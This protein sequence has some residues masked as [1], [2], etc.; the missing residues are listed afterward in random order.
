MADITRPAVLIVRDGWGRNPN[1]EHDAFN[2]VHLARTPACDRLLASYPWTLIQT[3][4]PAVGLPEGTMGNSEVGHQ[5]LGAGRVVD[6]DSV[7][8]SKAIEDG[9]FFEN[10]V[11]VRAI[12]ETKASGTAV[13]LMGIASDAGVHGRLDHL[14]A[15]LELCRRRGQ[16]NVYVHLFTDGRDTGPFTGIDYVQEV[17]AKID[18]IGVGQIASVVGRYYAMDRDNRWQRT[19]MAYRLLT[20]GNYAPEVG[21]YQTAAEA[22]QDYYDN[23]SGDSQTGDEFV[24]PRT[25]AP[26]GDPSPSRLSD[27]DG[28]IF[29]N[30]RGDRPR[31]IIRSLILPDE[32]WQQVPPSPDTGEPGFDRGNRPD[33]KVATMTRYEEGL[34]VDVAFP[35]PP[36]MKS[37]SG[38]TLA[39]LGLTQFRC[40]ETEKFA[41]VTFFFNDYREEPFEGEDREMAQS[42]SVATYD[43]APEMSAGEVAELVLGR[44]DAQTPPAFVLV[45]F[46]NGD[47]VGHTGDLEAATAA[48]ETVDEAVGRIIERV[49]ELGGTAVVTADHGNAEQMYDPETDAPHTSHT[50]YDVELIVVDDR[51]ADRAS[52]DGR[53]ASPGLRSGGC[54][55][56]VMPTV[57]DLMGLDRPAPM[58]GRSLLEGGSE[59]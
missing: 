24:L 37:I 58:T 51:Y 57:L 56:D 50:L 33:V 45:N 5:N 26:D 29:Y 53:T 30:Y 52:G 25:V 48:V 20:E 15:C 44:L 9:S 14:Y 17:Q 2:A 7:R 1:P 21:N 32:T 27:G 31:Q 39:E 41:H 10:P 4:G 38:Q 3:S 22:V 47:M 49:K 35:K 18:E 59:A 36:P 13:H 42:P 19:E 16:E 11:L 46:A 8:I 34:D 43:Q 6:Q 28:V 12:D 55:A 54:L 23:P 40:A